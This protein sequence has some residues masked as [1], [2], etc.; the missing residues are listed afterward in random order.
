[1]CVALLIHFSFNL[2]WWTY[3][4]EHIHL[5]QGFHNNHSFL[6]ITTC[7]LCSLTVQVIK[8][9]GDQHV[10]G[11]KADVQFS[12][13]TKPLRPLRRWAYVITVVQCDS[14]TL[15]T[16]AM[17]KLDLN[18][19]T[20]AHIQPCWLYVPIGPDWCWKNEAFAT[21]T[22][23]FTFKTWRVPVILERQKNFSIFFTCKP[24]QKINLL[25]VSQYLN[26]QTMLSQVFT[27]HQ[28]SLILKVMAQK[29][30][31]SSSPSQHFPWDFE[32]NKNKNLFL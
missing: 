3:L 5:Q 6:I 30:C 14:I 16:E 19:N 10:Y 24:F 12:I 21:F 11:K 20:N 22:F 31:H 8:G 29:F 13:L 17:T 9:Q 27:P 32:S 2:V 28:H 4:I 15:P 26:R 7:A 18:Y 1:M 23:P 25:C